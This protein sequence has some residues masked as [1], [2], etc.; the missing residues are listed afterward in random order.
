MY[1]VPNTTMYMIQKKEQPIDIE[2][3][4]YGTYFKI[5][6]LKTWRDKGRLAPSSSSLYK[7]L[8]MVEKL[9]GKPHCHDCKEK[10][11]PGEKIYCQTDKKHKI[12]YNPTYCRECQK[13][14]QKRKQTAEAL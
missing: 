14:R 4:K 2:N 11:Q 12:T 6:T 8:E 7:N 10:L 1:E 3:Q 9:L 5:T 13:K